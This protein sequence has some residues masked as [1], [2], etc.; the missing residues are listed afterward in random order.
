MGAAGMD[1]LAVRIVASALVDG[2]LAMLCGLL[3]A[4][5]W[6]RGQVLRLP[7]VSLFAGSLAAG[8][9]LQLLAL[10]AAFTGKTELRELLRELPDILRTH[11]GGVLGLSLAAALALLLV[12]LARGPRW[13][14]WM[15]LAAC[16]LFRAGTGHAATEN[17]FSLAQAMQLVHL[18]AMATWSGG[19]LVAGL[20]VLPRMV[21]G[22]SYGRLLAALSRSSTWA[23]GLVVVSGMYR[24][25]TGLEGDWHALVRT[26]WGLTLVAKLG[27]VGLAV[28]L[29][30]LNRLWLGHV[31][32]GDRRRSVR[33]LRVEA[34]VMVAILGLSATLANLPPPGD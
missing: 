32:A 4:R 23:L 5:C 7:Q 31:G 28:G 29:G 1:A 22:E 3:L 21:A 9:G 10:T 30:G 17:V 27:C 19:V 13:T 20:L 2:S 16:L 34:W 24:G 8:G 15:L 11:A 14:E 6:L 12:A 25:Y 26:G 18:A 33:V